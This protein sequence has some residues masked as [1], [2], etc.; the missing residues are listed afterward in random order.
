MKFDSVCIYKVDYQMKLTAHWPIFTTFPNLAK[1]YKEWKNLEIKR[2]ITEEG[3]L[4]F[5]FP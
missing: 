1:I 4:Q 2:K 5:H 3:I